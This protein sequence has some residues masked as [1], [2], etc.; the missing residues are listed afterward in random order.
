MTCGLCLRKRPCED[1]SVDR[2][3]EPCRC[4][5]GSY[6]ETRFHDDMDGTLHCTACDR[7]IVRCVP[8]K[9]ARSDIVVAIRKASRSL[10]AARYSRLLGHYSLASFSKKCLGEMPLSRLRELLQEMG[11]QTVEA[12]IKCEPCPGCGQPYV[13]G[14]PSCGY[15]I[16][17][18]RPDRACL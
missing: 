2:T 8:A 15:G 3:G 18:H 7:E 17:G 6:A 9:E 11:S 16:D 14:C 12:E 5:R 10:E 13:D 1:A 4:G